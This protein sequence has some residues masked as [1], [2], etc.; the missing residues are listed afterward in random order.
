MHGSAVRY[1]AMIAGNTRAPVLLGQLEDRRTPT[2]NISGKSPHTINILNTTLVRHVT[3][4][5]LAGFVPLWDTTLTRKGC[6]V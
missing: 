1:S 6:H 5:A 3:T 2:H 4:P